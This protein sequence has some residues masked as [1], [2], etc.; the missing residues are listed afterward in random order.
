MISLY[1][2]QQILWNKTLKGKMEYHW[3]S[4][5]QSQVKS[6]RIRKF[7]EILNWILLYS[8]QKKKPQTSYK[9]ECTYIILVTCSLME[10]VYIN[11]ERTILVCICTKC[12]GGIK[13]IFFPS[14]C[15]CSECSRCYRA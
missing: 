3:K 13:I 5:L 1:L 10:R 12:G 8:V 14:F 11:A 6:C 7:R 9:E 15:D 4:P 2:N